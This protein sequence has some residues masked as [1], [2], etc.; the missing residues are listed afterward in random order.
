[1]KRA[2][3]TWLGESNR[4]IKEKMCF[5][6]HDFSVSFIRSEFCSWLLAS[7]YPK[8]RTTCYLF[9]G[10]ILLFPGLVMTKEK[11]FILLNL[12]ILWLRIKF[13][14]SI[15]WP[16][17]CCLH[18]DTILSSSTPISLCWKLDPGHCIPL[19]APGCQVMF[20]ES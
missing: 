2:L 12:H 6:N 18:T 7:K 11:V 14:F 20:P 13:P 16:R 3:M 10:L 8:V 17:K 5:K 1:M 9:V 15:T 19:L 4:F